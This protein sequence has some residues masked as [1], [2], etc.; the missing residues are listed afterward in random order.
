MTITT[1][2]QTA[3]DL[4]A[5]YHKRDVRLCRFGFKMKQKQD[6]NDR[7]ASAITD[8]VAEKYQ[9]TLPDSR[10]TYDAMKRVL[11]NYAEKG[12]SEVNEL[13]NQIDGLA[14]MAYAIRSN[15]AFYADFEKDG[16]SKFRPMCFWYSRHRLDHVWNF[17]KS[18]IIRSRYNAFLEEAKDDQGRK[19]TDHYLPVHLVLTLPHK[20]G[21]YKGK[22][23]FARELIE[24]FRDLRKMPFWKEMV[25]AGE[26]G[27]EVKK[28][29]VHGLHIHLH[30]FILQKPEFTINEVRDEIEFHWKAKTGNTSTYSGIHYETLYIPE[31]TASGKFIKHYLKPGDDLKLYLKGVMECIKYHFK[32]GCL[33]REEVLNLKNGRQVIEKQFDIELIQDIISNT[34]NLRLYS[35]FGGF[36]KEKSLNFNL[37]DTEADDQAPDEVTEEIMGSSDQVEERLINPW[38][39]IPATRADYQILYGKANGFVHYTED[40]KIPFEPFRP[41][42]RMEILPPEYDLK[43]AIRMIATN[44]YSHYLSADWD[45]YSQETEFYL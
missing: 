42:E 3:P 17:R 31:K 16:Q 22:R 25:Y 29:K 6:M 8:F 14:R 9:I 13:E 28:S 11:F 40:S 38:T 34:K 32:P 7:L 15:K 26:Y 35:R 37:L 21:L 20:D 10:Q 1:P 45:S 4:L 36:Y 19:L 12:E 24:A 27:I 30:S 23:F 41:S 5:D 18:Q 44:R 39:G 2:H 33:E 43:E